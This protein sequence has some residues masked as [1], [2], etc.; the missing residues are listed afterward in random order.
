[1]HPL[2]ARQ[3]KRFFK[4]APLPSEP[5]LTA[6]L[7]AVDAAY[8]SADDDRALLEHSIALSS[9]ELTERNS[10]LQADIE[11]RKRAE[12]ERDA[13]F[14]MS[15]DLLCIIDERFIL[16]QTN[17]SWTR[18]LGFPEGAL[19]GRTLLDLVHPDDRRRTSAEATAL[20]ASGAVVGFENRFRAHDGSWRRLSWSATADRPRG[21]FFAVA[22]DVTEQRALERDLAQ[23]Q[24]LEAVGQ[25]A[26]GMAHEV[27][28]PVQF[29]GDN[30]Q[31]VADSFDEL[32]GYLQAAQALADQGS[33][34]A[35]ELAALAAIATKVDLPYLLVELP[36]SLSEARDGVR[37]V[38]ELVRA[39]KEYA[40]PDT[41]EMA[42]GDVNQAMERALVL[43]RNE[44]K[45]V[46]AVEKELG[47][48]PQIDCHIGSLHQVFLNL[49]VNAAHA[50]EDKQA[51]H[52]D[53]KRG[54]IKVATR[55]ER[56]AVIISI[57]DSGCGIP[58]E[59]RERIFE[60]FFTTKPVGKGSGQ[61]LPLV[62]AVIEK[63]QGK[64]EID[65]E[66]GVGTTFTL[67]LPTA[68]LKAA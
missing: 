45:Y 56:E 6:L 3:L 57:Q 25:L 2:L 48:L 1:V 15:P 24:K 54:G 10:E 40:H 43:A 21:L 46:A 61:G 18:Q 39:L 32:T 58:A 19:V 17:P 60:P 31:F 7:E 13:F 30:V 68:Q 20:S 37:R 34:S 26:S 51:Q 55:T 52:P 35:P 67:R 16:A 27:N 12:H 66:V 14:R 65:S 8:V 38:A 50:I 63:H 33:A 49:L 28:T 64:I 42:P 11:A 22:R 59:L 4:G 9:K 47:P 29:I 41:P 23:A 53:G 5:A 36:K 62:R 44:L